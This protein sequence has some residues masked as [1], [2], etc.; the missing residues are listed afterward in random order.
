MLPPCCPGSVVFH[1]GHKAETNCVLGFGRSGSPCIVNALCQKMR[2]LRSWSV[3]SV[4]RLQ[5]AMDLHEKQTAHRI[6]ACADPSRQSAIVARA[7]VV[8]ALENLHEGC[9]KTSPRPLGSSN[10]ATSTAQNYT[11]SPQRVTLVNTSYHPS[12]L[13]R[14]SFEVIVKTFLVSPKRFL[15]TREAKPAPRRCTRSL[16]SVRSQ[17]AAEGVTVGVRTG[18]RSPNKVRHT[19]SESSL[20]DDHG[21][22]DI[23][24]GCGWEHGVDQ[25]GNECSRFVW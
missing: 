20:H 6:D 12:R 17:S 3:A 22:R 11:S 23:I 19:A 25:S 24:E 2:K 16:L 10:A 7:A 15:T 14:Q 4:Q 13:K 21:R 18:G 9:G 1:E 8:V 5:S